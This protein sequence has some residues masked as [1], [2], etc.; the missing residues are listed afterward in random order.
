[1]TY[2]ASKSGTVGIENGDYDRRLKHFWQSR[3]FSGWNHRE[4]N[5]CPRGAW[6]DWVE[7]A[8]FIMAKEAER[9]ALA[10]EAEAA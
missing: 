3:S 7:F 5:Y 1:M 9:K 6:S 8:E 2:F 4:F 10:K